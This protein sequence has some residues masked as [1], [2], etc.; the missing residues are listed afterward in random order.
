MTR[1][2]HGLADSRMKAFAGHENGRRTSCYHFA[3]EFGSTGRDLRAVAALRSPSSTSRQAFHAAWPDPC[4][5]SQSAIRKAATSRGTTA[6][7]EN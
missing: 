2:S 1:M 7:R 3:T 5:F 6:V 4:R